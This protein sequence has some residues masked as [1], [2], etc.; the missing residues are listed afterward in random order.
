MILN[1][2]GRKITKQIIIISKFCIMIDLSSWIAT[3]MILNSS[4]LD[5]ILINISTRFSTHEI[6]ILGMSDYLSF[7]IHATKT[8]NTCYEFMPDMSVDCWY[9]LALISTKKKEKEKNYRVNAHA[10]HSIK[11][12]EDFWYVK[13][14]K[15]CYNNINICWSCSYG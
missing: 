5:E 6:L 3:T 10:R 7:V 15:Y 11:S 8:E 14:N 12:L 9:S 4:Y 13:P 1:L 2:L